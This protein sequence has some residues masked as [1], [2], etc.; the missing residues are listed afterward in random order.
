MIEA[1]AQRPDVRTAVTNAA[2]AALGTSDVD[3]ERSFLEQ[4][5]DSLSAVVL[6]AL[7]VIFHLTGHGFVGH[8]G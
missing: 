7:V 4:G 6:V 5:G 1:G 3:G 2:G 8:H